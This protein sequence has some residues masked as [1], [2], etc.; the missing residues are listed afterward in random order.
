MSVH[1]REGEWRTIASRFR[2][3]GV[4]ENEYLALAM[5]GIQFDSRLFPVLPILEK[6]AM[7]FYCLYV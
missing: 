4:P 3:R 2:K 6:M 1:S 5:P 7:N